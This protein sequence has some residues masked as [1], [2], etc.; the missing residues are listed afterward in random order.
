MLI[1][2]VWERERMGEGADQGLGGTGLL[3]LDHCPL[4]DLLL[5][6]LGLMLPTSSTFSLSKGKVG[7]GS[8][9]S[10]FL[11]LAQ[12]ETELGFLRLIIKWIK[13]FSFTVT[14]PAP[15]HLSLALFPARGSRLGGRGMTCCVLPEQLAC[16]SSCWG[17]IYGW[18]SEHSSPDLCSPDLSAGEVPGS[19]A[20]ILIPITVGWEPIHKDCLWQALSCRSGLTL[21]RHHCHQPQRE[22]K[23]HWA[24][25]QA[26]QQAGEAGH[27]ALR[28]EGESRG[29]MRRKNM[30]DMMSHHL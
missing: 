3:G 1:M 4:Q 27:G 14:L 15:V 16:A 7:V 20:S 2:C 23:L 21:S 17:E 12:E 8:V 26:S 13:M 28:L 10:H 18:L 6:A 11:W 5:D 25:P 29:S 24:Q 9:T 22:R 30:K 19:R